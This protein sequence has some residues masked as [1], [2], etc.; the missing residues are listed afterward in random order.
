MGASHAKADETDVDEAYYRIVSEASNLQFNK[1]KEFKLNKI[2][3]STYYRP[4]GLDGDNVASPSIFFKILKLRCLAINI[5]IKLHGYYAGYGE[6]NTQIYIIKLHPQKT[7]K[8]IV[9]AIYLYTSLP[10]RYSDNSNSNYFSCPRDITPSK[11][12]Y[13]I[14]T[15]HRIKIS[16][17]SELMHP[18]MNV[19]YKDILCIDQDFTFVEVNGI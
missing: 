4:T 2:W 1:P 17:V 15:E 10:E 12:E 8:E 13:Q 16:G 5:L 6:E 19:K 7:R 18:N 3:Y 9:N 14:R 11:I